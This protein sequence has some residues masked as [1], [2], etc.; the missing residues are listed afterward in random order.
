MNISSTTTLGQSGPA[1]NGNKGVL[2]IPQSSIT[3]TSPSDYLVPYPGHTLGEFYPSA[4]MQSMYSAA[5]ANWAIPF[6]HQ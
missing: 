5:P 4:E 6:Y 2:H 3:G 1:G